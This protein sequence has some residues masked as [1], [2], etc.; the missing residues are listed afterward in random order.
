MLTMFVMVIMSLM[1]V[2]APKEESAPPMAEVCVPAPDY[3]YVRVYGGMDRIR[4]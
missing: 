3:A 4:Y 1:G 2:E